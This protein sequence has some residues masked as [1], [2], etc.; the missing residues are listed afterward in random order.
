[1]T[2]LLLALL[3][4][5]A[6]DST[7]TD[8]G[9]TDTE[10]I[11]TDVEPACAAAGVVTAEV[12]TLTTR[13][14]VALEADRY[15]GQPGCPGIVLLHMIPPSNTRADWPDNFI[16]KL[17]AH[18]W[19]VLALDRRGAGGSAGEPVDSYQGTGGAY[20][21]EAAVGAHTQIGAEGMVLIG[22]S[23]GTTSVLDYAIWAP[24]EG[25]PEAVA[26]GFM[27]G[28][29]YTESQNDMADAPDI[30][31]VFTFS[32][33]ENG[34]SLE[35]ENLSR[36]NWTMLEYPGGAHGTQMF[37]AKPAVKGDIESWLVDVLGE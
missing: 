17:T 29:S 25:L 34:W 22:A 16:S 21:A 36:D 2:P 8:S 20:D 5:G 11:D 30:P 24:T 37:S 10:L 23:N 27:T 15:A 33:A 13:D 3:A 28:G 18:G 19:S 6:D 9:T 35:Q 32:T 26:M 7:D 1:M 12:L 31:A 14:G 4:C